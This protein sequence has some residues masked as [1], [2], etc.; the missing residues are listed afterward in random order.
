M[1]D[2]QQRESVLFGER[3]LI[4]VLGKGRHG[5]KR[6]GD[7]VGTAVCGAMSGILTATMRM[8]SHPKTTT[9]KV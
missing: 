6:W 3:G 5:A 2:V 4:M 7:E 1:T 8:I 9:K